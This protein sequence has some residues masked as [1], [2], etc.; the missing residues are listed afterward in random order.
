ML[1]QGYAT[2]CFA[3]YDM[4]GFAVQGTI[5]ELVVSIWGSC[6]V[7]PLSGYARGFGLVILPSLFLGRVAR[8]H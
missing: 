5:E 1:C 2:L 7:Q 4:P 8:V 3:C 6:T